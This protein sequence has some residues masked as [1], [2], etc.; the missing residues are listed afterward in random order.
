MCGQAFDGSLEVDGRVATLTLRGEADLAS[1][2]AFDALVE[3]TLAAD[4]DRIIV[5]VQH[6]NYLES[7]C[8][9]RLLGAHE[10]AATRGGTFVVRGAAG[11]VLRV[12]EVAGVADELLEPPDADA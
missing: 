1:R 4:V 3:E 11:I 10:R 5:D 7:A 8:L 12:L 2:E 6:L 9:R